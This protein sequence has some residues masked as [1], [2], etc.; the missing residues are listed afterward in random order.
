MTGLNDERLLR[1]V[2]DN[3]YSKLVV[4]LDSED[5]YIE[6]VEAIYY[7]KE[8]IE[9]LSSN[10][11]K[12][13]YFGYTSDELTTFFQGTR[14]VF[15]I[16]DDGQTIVV[17][18]QTVSD[19]VYIKAM[20]D[21]IIGTG[22]ILLCVTIS[23]VAAPAAPAIS[24]IFMASATTGTTFALESGTI[25]FV[26]AAIAKG[27]ETESFE[28]AMRA[29]V[30]SAGSGFKYGAISG[31]IAGGVSKTNAL[32]KASRAAKGKNKSTEKVAENIAENA[33]EASNTIP[34]WQESE[35]AVLKKYGGREQVA[36]LAGEEV[37]FSTPGGTRPDVVREIGKKLEAIEVKNYN[38]ANSANRSELYSVLEKEVA[39]RVEN[40]PPKATQRIVLDVRNRGFNEELII[41]VKEAITKR[42]ADIYPNIPI[43]ILGEVL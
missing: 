42:L 16:G 33:A 18:M 7:P 35:Q 43:D 25:S 6:N 12:N 30:E 28:Q 31:V 21:V 9:A 20:E 13:I 1:Y 24:T 15:T 29:G 34:S 10:T 4:E 22:V 27:Y 41:Q 26:A 37:P 36:Y 11:Q 5:Y 2:E 8:Y 19:E 39:A 38:L 23:A 32:R 17:P 3:V 40:L 14:Y